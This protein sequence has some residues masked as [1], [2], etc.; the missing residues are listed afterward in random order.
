M[1]IAERAPNVFDPDLIYLL[2]SKRWLA[3]AIAKTDGD[4]PAPNDILIDTEIKCERHITKHGFWYNGGRGCQTCTLAIPVE[5]ARVTK[6]LEERKLPYVLKLTQSLSS[7]G[8]NIV[9]TEDQRSDTT[10]K[11]RRTLLDY[12]PRISKE[13][14]HLYPMTKVLSDL[15]PGRTMALNFFVRRDG[16]CLFSGACHQLATGMT[17]RQN[18]A[19]TYADQEKLEQHYRPTLEKMSKL[20]HN[21]GYYGQVGIDIMED[22]E[23]GKQYV[24]DAN[25]R[26][27][28][29]MLLYQLRGH[30]ERHGHKMAMVYECIFMSVPREEFE[31]N[32][33]DEFEEARIV[34]LG[35]TKLGK[36][37]VWGFGVVLA[38]ADK[39]ELDDLSDRIL[40]LETKAHTVP[41]D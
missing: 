33:S 31:E 13:N 7:V 38:G 4:L 15:I 1:D 16:S 21:E 40:K 5:A 37:N 3:D 35:G 22:A 10:K 34:I 6:I 11:I 25:V 39:D 17:G 8:T 28:L 23:N 27:A 32:F 41:S 2:N 19:I 36:K 20:L 30:F 9:T 12:L 29:S 24:I 14:A 18:T 26:T